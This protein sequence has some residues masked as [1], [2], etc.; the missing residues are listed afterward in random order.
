MYRLQMANAERR[1]QVILVTSA[2]EG[3]GKTTTS[4]NL[5]LALAR[6]GHSHRARRAGP[7]AARATSCLRLHLPARADR[8]AA[9]PLRAGRSAGARGLRAD[10]GTG[11]GRQW[12]R[13]GGGQ[14]RRAAGRAQP[15]APQRHD[16]AP[17][18]AGRAWPLSGS[19]S[20]SSSSTRHRWSREA[21]ESRS[22][23]WRTRCS[24]SRGSEASIA[25]ACSSFA[26]V[27]RHPGSRRR[28]GRHRRRAR[29]LGSLAPLLPGRPARG[30]GPGSGRLTGRRR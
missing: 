27:C 20:R 29:R 26:G 2:V 8:R 30:P 15:V 17:D 1:A 5:A 16:R 10:R 12:R 25:T 18:P 7:L 24:W 4:A 21:M 22:P 11:S 9:R 14:P 23:Q 19:A 6:A 3:E 28:R 13:P